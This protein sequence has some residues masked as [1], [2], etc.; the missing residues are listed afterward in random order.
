MEALHE[1]A[2]RTIEE[3]FGDRLKRRPSRE[4]ES[5]HEGA[6]ASVLPVNPEEVEFL[7]K[8]A[9]RYSVP[10]VALGAETA[11]EPVAEKGSILVRFDLMR[12]LWL[13]GSEEVW[14]RAEPGA[15][16]LELDNNLSARGWGLAVYPTSA[17]RATIGGWLALDGLGVGS[18]EYGWLRENVLSA[19]VVL[20]GGE[21]QTVRGEEL[22][23]VLSAQG[24]GGIVVATTLRTRRADADVPFA[25]AFASPEDLAGAVTSIFDAGAPLWHLAFLSPEMAHARGLGEDHLL[26]GAYPGERA[27]TI[28]KTLRDVASSYRGRELPSADAYRVWG[29]R[30]FPVAPSRPTP[31]PVER[32]LVPLPGI[33]Q[34]LESH[35]SEAVQGTVA[36][37]G[38]A[39]I[40]AY[41]A[42]KE[43][44]RR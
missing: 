6:L 11:Y 8:V 36:R 4:G 21:R 43:G 9:E 5:A 35:P 19:D 22:H 32:T 23:S 34:R 37:S 10:L 2:L 3:T 1:E 33:A 28:E 25:Q 31:A 16:W 30:F 14:V 40:L 7:A 39:L 29:E 12:G 27:A 44:W 41:D 18:F 24:G 42:Q 13:R 17:P 38:E 20:P 15:L 26:F